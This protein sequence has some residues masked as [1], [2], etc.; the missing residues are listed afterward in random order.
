MSGDWPKDFLDV[1]MIALPNKNQ[2][3]KCSDHRTI[4]LISHTGTIV[5]RILSK[6]LEN[7]IEEVIEEDQYGFRKGKGTRDAIG[8]MRI[9]SERVLDVKE[10]ICLCFIDWQKAF[11]RV[12]WTK[13]LE[14][15][16]NIR[17]N[18]RERRLIRNLYMGQ[19]VKLR[20]N[21]GGT[22]SFQIGRGV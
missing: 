19:R 10:E 21:Q 5:V 7:K 18:W 22:E 20:I 4:S 16:R 12:D 14:I 1:T 3:K 6:R 13:L 15:L 8:L 9:I 17:V 2:A 11:D